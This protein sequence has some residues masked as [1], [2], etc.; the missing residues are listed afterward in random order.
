MTVKV[1]I[2]GP[3]RACAGGAREV[4]G[5]GATLREVLDDL[6]LR[7]PV[8]ERRLRDERGVLRPH[9]LVYVDGVSVRGAADQDTSLRDGAEV[10]IAPAVSGG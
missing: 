10:F 2:P 1:V 5:E 9:V 8:L 7:L 6:A 3:L 4:D